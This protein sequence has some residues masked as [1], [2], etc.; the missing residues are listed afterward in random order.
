MTRRAGAAPPA[1]GPGAVA[2]TR[3]RPARSRSVPDRRAAAAAAVDVVASRPWRISSLRS[4]A[5]YLLIHERIT[6]GGAGGSDAARAAAERRFRTPRA[7]SLR[8][9]TS[10]LRARRLGRAPI[11]VI[12]RALEEVPEIRLEVRRVGELR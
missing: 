10:V 4:G 12:L 11:D 9:A 5:E 8:S 3:R 7:P 1:A 6:S 2:P